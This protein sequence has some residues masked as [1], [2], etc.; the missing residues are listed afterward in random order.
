MEESLQRL[1][2]WHTG[3]VRATAIS[4][5]QSESDS[6]VVTTNHIH[7]TVPALV[8]PVEFAVLVIHTHDDAKN[9]YLIRHQE[10]QLASEMSTSIGNFLLFPYGQT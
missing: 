5:S 6:K 2:T 8:M 3:I 7:S 1:Q 9:I 10:M 4:V